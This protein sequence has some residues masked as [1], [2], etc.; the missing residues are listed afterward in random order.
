MSLDGD[1]FKDNIWTD[2]GTYI[3]K[4]AY[5]MDKYIDMYLLTRNKYWL[6]KYVDHMDS[7]LSQRQGYI[8]KELST[9][10]AW[11]GFSGAIVFSIPRF[12]KIV[13]YYEFS[14]YYNKAEEYVI[15][16][17]NAIEFFNKD[18]VT[19]HWIFNTD[20]PD[21][22]IRGKAAAYDMQSLLATAAL[23]L[24]ECQQ[25]DNTTITNM[26]SKATLYAAYFKTKLVDYGAY[27][28]WNFAPYSI[29]NNVTSLDDVG[30]ANF[31]VLF[32]YEAFIR[33]ITFTSTDMMKF[34]GTLNNII[35]SDSTV[36]HNLIDGIT[37]LVGVAKV[38]YY[39]VYVAKFNGVIP[40][41][42]NNYL[43]PDFIEL[44]SIEYS[45]IV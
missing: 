8:W 44:I 11:L 10:Y 6:D 32:T 5:I 33:N 29:P 30:H 14:E 40:N 37:D 28:L 16:A 1:W 21:I 34:A 15:A 3:W 19:D 36:P 22:S 41:R 23:R 25:L 12:S 24:T 31:N 7:V 4:E 20:A 17:K 27:Y 38:L 18:W 26:L 42:L 2:S 9:N 39:W 43:N 35:K 45:K 13:T